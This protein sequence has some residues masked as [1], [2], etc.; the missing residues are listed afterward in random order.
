MVAVAAL[1]Y[2][3]TLLP[4]E[5]PQL[6]LHCCQL[7]VVALPAPALPDHLHFLP[8]LHA[9]AVFWGLMCL[10][11]A[12]EGESVEVGHVDHLCIDYRI[13][14]QLLLPISILSLEGLGQFVP[15]LVGSKVFQQSGVGRQEVVLGAALRD[16]GKGLLVD[17]SELYHEVEHGKGHHATVQ[18]LRHH[19]YSLQPNSQAVL[20]GRN[21]LQQ[22]GKGKGLILS[23]LGWEVV[24]EECDVL[25]RV[26]MEF[27]WGEVEEEGYFVVEEEFLLLNA[28]A[29]TRQAW[30]LAK[31]SPSK[32][33][34]T[35][36]REE[37]RGRG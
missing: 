27:E 5:L 7:A 17:P 4:Y 28:V 29:G 14:Q 11:V 19:H 35:W 22:S 1:L 6:G 10:W 26:G 31:K 32:S 15:L 2:D 12:M 21:G 9:T 16:E 23:I 37:Q 36:R 33:L 34:T 13:G 24:G 3:C 20:H 8:E 18:S 30:K 25:G